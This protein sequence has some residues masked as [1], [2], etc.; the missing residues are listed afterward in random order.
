MMYRYRVAV[1]LG[2][3]TLAVPAAAVQP[4]QSLSGQQRSVQ[5]SSAERW[6]QQLENE[7]DHLQEDLLY[8]RGVYPAGLEDQ[9]EDASRAVA[10]FRR[11]LRRERDRQ[12]LIRDF[13]EMDQQVHRLVQQ[14]TESGDG[15]LRRQASRISYADE[16]LHYVLRTRA[17]DDQVDPV[18]RELIARHAHVLESESSNLRDMAERFGRRE[19]ALRD[20][21]SKFADEAEH[22]H[23]VV[24]RGAD[25]GHLA[26]DFQE[27]DTAWHG[28]VEHI[29]RSASRVYLLRR[30]HD[31]NRVH[32][33]LH[34]LLAGGHGAHHGPAEVERR[35]A[36]PVE[37]R[38]FDNRRDRP[39]IQIEIPGLGR[40][41]FPR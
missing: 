33:Q 3:L 11:V 38:P 12:H 8:E 24:E 2:M 35:P 10:H 4:P 32:N 40:V 23:E 39:R 34:D 20:A 19:P 41:E 31:V 1:C 22:F 15:W 25:V 26:S 21:L 37:G 18:S 30:A 17:A 5:R 9:A 36:P 13:E 27:V 7:I 28:A 16:Q 14:L 6:V 29:N